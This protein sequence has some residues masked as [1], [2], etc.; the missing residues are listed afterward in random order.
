MDRF[1]YL[2]EQTGVSDR[3]NWRGPVTYYSYF[4]GRESGEGGVSC[5][6]SALVLYYARPS[7]YISQGGCD[8][9][10]SPYYVTDV[11]DWDSNYGESTQMLLKKRSIKNLLPHNTSE[12]GR[13]TGEGNLSAFKYIWVFR[14]FSITSCT[15]HRFKISWRTWEIDKVL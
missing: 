11:T 2:F 3:R 8:H 7:H 1:Y 13:G 12:G 4:L 10:L 15:L 5:L 9:T 14:S 6:L